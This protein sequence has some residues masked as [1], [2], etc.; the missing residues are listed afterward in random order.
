MKNF[1]IWLVKLPFVL[2][3]VALILAFGIT[4]CLL[5]VLGV[6]LTPVFGVGLIILPIGLILLGLAWLIGKAL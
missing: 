2:I 1:L 5:S 4:G 6:G 3:A